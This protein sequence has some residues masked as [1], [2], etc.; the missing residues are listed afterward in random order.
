MDCLCRCSPTGP[1]SYAD[2]SERL[3]RKLHVIADVVRLYVPWLMDLGVIPID[4][5]GMICGRQT[6]SVDESKTVRDMASMTR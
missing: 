2:D 6:V 5:N 4:S 3:T 1:H